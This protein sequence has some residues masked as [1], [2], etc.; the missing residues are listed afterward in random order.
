MTLSFS[1][2]PFRFRRLDE[3]RGIVISSIGDF[4]HVTNDE[5]DQLIFKPSELP[6]PLLAKAKARFLLGNQKSPAIRRLMRSRIQARRETV[7]SGPSLH[8]IVPTLLCGHSCRYCQVSRA[9]GDS[10]Y[11]MS[12]QQLARVCDL[13][14]ESPS[15]TLT[16][17]F[18]GG[19]PLIRYDLVKEAIERISERNEHEGRSIRY[20]VAS[21]LHQLTHEMCD[22]FRKHQVFLST[23]LDGPAYLHN[24]NRPIPTRD[25]YER[26]VAGVAMA[27]ELVGKDSVAALMTTTKESLRHA[28]AIVDEYVKLQF[29]EV[30]I[31]PINCHGFARRQK[32][33]NDYSIDEFM[34]FYRKAFERV[35]YWNEKG[36]NI[37]EVAAVLAFN[38]MLSPFDA[39]YVDLQTPTGAGLAAL[40]Y[41]YDGWVYPSDEARMIAET[42][43]TSLRLGVIESSLGNLLNSAVQ[44]NL[45]R[46]SLPQNNDACR[47]C[48]YHNYCGPDPV[49]AYRQW[50]TY[51]VASDRTDHCQR[52]RKLFD[53]LFRQLADR[54]EEFGDLAADWAQTTTSSECTQ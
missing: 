21:T 31:R 13:I 46:S 26:T 52:Q 24:R 37:R 35:I 50:G 6:L 33:D 1:H 19:D 7:L 43:D 42:G 49:D 8:M 10:G 25:S 44:R 41:H 48:A 9:V 12:R 29:P 16:V 38:K 47:E 54:G 45:I 28:D 51:Q 53:F 39:G 23:S 30:F 14:F 3:Q 11:T 2:F 5:L 4:L 22:F 40:L 32:V 20:V 17:E 18:Q 15:R 27:R 34:C 36:V